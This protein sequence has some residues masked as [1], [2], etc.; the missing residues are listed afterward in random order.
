MSAGR[1]VAIWLKRFKGGPMDSVAAATLEPGAGLAGNANRGG[2]RQVTLLEREVWE[3]VL[4][5]LGAELPPSTRRANLLVEATPLVRTTHRVL[6]IGE[7]RLRILGPTQPCNLMEESWP[8]L[9]TAL[10]RD[11]RGGAFAEVLEGGPIRCG[12][13]IAWEA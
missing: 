5:E 8:G 10:R 1:L 7:A 2:R 4:R 9:E 13:P 6:R 12:D 3:A 11:W